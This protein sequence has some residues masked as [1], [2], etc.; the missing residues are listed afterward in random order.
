MILL[1]NYTEAHN[2]RLT[3][4]PRTV[5]ILDGWFLGWVWSE[6]VESAPGDEVHK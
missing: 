1:P 6:F 3:G 4:K 2:D 5:S